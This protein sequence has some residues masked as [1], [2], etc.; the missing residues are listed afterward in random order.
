MESA[1]AGAV[2]APAGPPVAAA[3]VGEQ[4]GAPLPGKKKVSA[5]VVVKDLKERIKSQDGKLKART[6]RGY[7]S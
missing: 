7:Y 2:S 3:A 5:A 1:T 4:G 6:M